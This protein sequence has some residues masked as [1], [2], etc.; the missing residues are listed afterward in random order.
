MANERLVVIGNGMAGAR[1]VEDLIKRGGG[2]RFD[3][4]VFGDEPCGNYNRILL[5]SVLSG[6]HKPD[7]IFLNPISWYAANGVTLHAGRRVERIDV[8]GQA[9]ARIRWIV[10]A[11]RHARHRDRQQPG[12]SA[13]RER[14]RR[15]RPIQGWRLRVSHAR[16]LPSHPE[17]RGQRRGE[18]R[19]LAVDCWGSRRP[20][21]C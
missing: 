1:L 8:H 6:S 17:P 5:S 9:R 2:N 4:I 15:R 3:V 14:S 19:S 13:N 20:A 16:R 18:R 7:D 11:V 21:G 12:C 10:G